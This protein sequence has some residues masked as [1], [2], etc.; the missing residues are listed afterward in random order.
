[1]PSLARS[2][3]KTSRSA[4]ATR[5][6]KKEVGAITKK[7]AL[8]LLKEDHRKVEDLFEQIKSARKTERKQALAQTICEE[9]TVHAAVEETAFYPAVRDALKSKKDQDRLDEAEVEHSTFKWLIARLQN[10]SPD[11]KLFT[12][13]VTVLKEYVEHH[14][15]EEETQMFP[16]VRKSSL[17][18]RALGQVL[19]DT[20]LS[21]QKKRKH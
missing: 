1:M 13:L 21:L 15:E 12:A 19:Q 5:T 7:D 6:R 11:T 4:A 16:Q 17:D 14:V 18:T 10:E 20:K 8:T 3:T 2:S 9:L